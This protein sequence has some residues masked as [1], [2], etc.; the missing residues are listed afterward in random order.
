VER[1]NVAAGSHL[2]DRFEVRDTDSIMQSM[3]LM[4]AAAEETARSAIDSLPILEV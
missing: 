4:S 3:R 1:A 2:H